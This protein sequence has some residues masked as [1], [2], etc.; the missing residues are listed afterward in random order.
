MTAGAALTRRRS[1]SD[2]ES[3]IWAIVVGAGFLVGLI[4]GRVWA[5]AAVVPFAIWVLLTNEL[6]GDLGEVVA[7]VGSCLIA[8]GILAGVFTRRLVRRRARPG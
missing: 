7:V 4:V 3:V 1:P 5:L 2:D 8:G 6:E